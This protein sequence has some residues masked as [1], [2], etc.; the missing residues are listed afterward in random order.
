M[1][2]RLSKSEGRILN[3]YVD[4]RNTELNR[5][6]EAPYYVHKWTDGSVY[7]ERKPEVI[8]QKD[9][10]GKIRTRYDGN[11]EPIIIYPSNRYLL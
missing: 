3:A 4:K 9:N 1:I 6:N 8:E 10:V 2:G 5:I 7:P 11:P